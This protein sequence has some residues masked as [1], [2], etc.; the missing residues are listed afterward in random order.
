MFLVVFP[1]RKI[2]TGVYSSLPDLIKNCW[3][4]T[5]RANKKVKP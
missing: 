1:K 3:S 2:G 5:L 4:V